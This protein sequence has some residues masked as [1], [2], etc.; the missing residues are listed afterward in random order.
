LVCRFFCKNLFAV[1]L[2]H[3]LFNSKFFFSASC[4]EFY[5]FGVAHLD[6]GYDLL[7]LLFAILLGF[8][9]LLTHCL[10]LFEHLF[11][12]L[13]KNLLLSHSFFL[14]LAHLLDNGKGSLTRCLHTSV[15]SVSLPLKVL[16]S[17]DLH[18]H[19][20]AIFLVFLSLNET[21][22]FFK[23]LVVEY[24][25]VHFL[26]IILFLVKQLLSPLDN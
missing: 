20:N 7:D 9:I 17:S 16:K 12:F 21:L 11:S 6:F 18:L 19:V 14:V 3:L 2:E 13:L 5:A 10:N 4:L 8:S 24:H 23:L 26:D 22:V 25:A 15:L 1:V